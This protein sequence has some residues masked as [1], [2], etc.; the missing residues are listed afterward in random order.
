MTTSTKLLNSAI[1]IQESR[2]AE[3]DTS[4]KERN[5]GKV[6]TAFNTITGQNLT[7]VE[8][9]EFMCVLKQVRYF[10][11]AQA[12]Q[13]HNDSLLD[14]VS[15]ASLLGEAGWTDG[16]TPV[17][18]DPSLPT[19]NPMEVYLK[20]TSSMLE[21][22]AAAYAYLN[23]LDP[24]TDSEQIEEYVKSLKDLSMSS[25]TKEPLDDSAE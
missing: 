12:G 24:A 25:Q 13:S 2:G 23:S 15:Y 8:G 4:Q 6:V 7:E 18:A 3:Y 14:L 1:T 19:A 11:A 5:M 10:S 17:N 16:G 22:K 9:W 20:R 21:C